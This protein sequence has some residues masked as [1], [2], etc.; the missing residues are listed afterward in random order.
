MCGRISRSPKQ[1]PDL[2]ST[3]ARTC[4]YVE[5]RTATVGHLK[6]GPEK[7]DGDP[8]SRLGL[9]NGGTN[10]AKC[11]LAIN[12]RADAIARTYR[13]CAGGDKWNM[14]H[15]AAAST[16]PVFAVGSLST[17]VPSQSEM[18]RPECIAYPR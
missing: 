1:H 11:G 9:I 13:V 15:S 4:Q 2:E 8:H 10:P 16:Q 18:I 14:S 17:T 7:R 6:A 3:L 12:E 5:E